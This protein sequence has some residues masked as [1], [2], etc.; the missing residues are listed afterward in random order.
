MIM[1]YQH[2]ILAALFLSGITS[3]NS[4]TKPGEAKESTPVATIAEDSTATETTTPAEN[5]EVNEQETQAQKTFLETF[6]DGLDENFEP[7][8]VSKFITPNAKQILIDGYDYDCETGDCL[9]I[10]LFAY[11]GGGDTGPCLSRSIKPQGA[12]KFLV[13]HKYEDEEYNVVLT[14]IKEG[15]TYKIDDIKKQ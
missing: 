4:S 10:W 5:A 15:D 11:E 12:N 7:D 14:L 8:Y 9:A 1:K 2:F 13:T 6:Y 3:C